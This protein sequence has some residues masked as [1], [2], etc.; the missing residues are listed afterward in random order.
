MPPRHQPCGSFLLRSRIAP[1][2]GLSL[3]IASERHD[4][5]PVAEICCKAAVLNLARVRAVLYRNSANLAL[6]AAGHD[7]RKEL[8]SCFDD[9]A[10]YRVG[11][12]SKTRN[13]RFVSELH[14]ATRHLFLDEIS[15]NGGPRTSW[16]K[17]CVQ[18]Q[19]G[20]R[21]WWLAHRFC[22]RAG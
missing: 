1:Q 4:G 7:R 19:R 12:C 6:S 15:L 2:L 16:V 13:R 21:S 14:R 10:R 9:E 17:V 3:H 18:R 5:L 11:R 22:S 8:K 20:D